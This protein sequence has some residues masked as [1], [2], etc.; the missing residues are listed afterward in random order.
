MTMGHRNQQRADQD[1]SR[2]HAR[3][4]LPGH[5][6]GC[7]QERL[8]VRMCDASQQGDVGLEDWAPVQGSKVPDLGLKALLE[9]TCT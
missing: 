1:G 6:V 2:Q 9:A 8:L 3:L 7:P 4:E 5:L